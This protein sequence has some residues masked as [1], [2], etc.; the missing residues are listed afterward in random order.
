MKNEFVKNKQNQSYI[1]EQHH[2]F[3]YHDTHHDGSVS[4]KPDAPLYHNKESAGL[5][6]ALP[7]TAEADRSFAKKLP[8]SNE[9]LDSFP[10]LSKRSLTSSSTR[11][12]SRFFPP[13]PSSLNK[14][15]ATWENAAVFGSANPDF[16]VFLEGLTEFQLRPE[17]ILNLP[18]S[19]TSQSGSPA[20]ADTEVNISQQRKVSQDHVPTHTTKDARISRIH[21]FS[22]AAQVPTIAEVASPYATSS[23][24]LA[25]APYSQDEA[26]FHRL[27][28]LPDNYS[29]LRTTSPSKDSELFPADFDF[30]P[31]ENDGG[32]SKGPVASFDD[33]FVLVSASASQMTQNGLTFQRGVTKIENIEEIANL[34]DNHKSLVTTRPSLSWVANVGDWRSREAAPSSASGGIVGQRSFD[35]PSATNAVVPFSSGG[36]HGRETS[37]Q[38]SSSHTA[39]ALSRYRWRHSN[40]VCVHKPFR[41]MQNILYPRAGN[42]PLSEE[43]KSRRVQIGISPNYQGNPNNPRNRSAQIPESENCSLFV[44]NLPS[45]CTYNELL[46]AIADHRP[47]RV[48]SVYINPPREESTEMKRLIAEAATRSHHMY[49]PVPASFVNSAAKVI[50]YHPSE[51]QRLL[52]LARGRGGFLVR[53]RRA[54]VKYN[55]HRT[56]A[57]SY[58]YPTSRVISITGPATIVSEIYL[59]SLFDQYFQYHTEKIIVLGET[60]ELRCLEWRFG[61]MRAQAHSAYQLLKTHYPGVVDVVSSTCPRRETPAPIF[62]ASACRS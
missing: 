62:P 3:L 44:T 54:H 5:I 1:K 53:N 57:Q 27:K 12:V 50:F 43:Q 4:E 10:D 24:R 15:S 19:A 46:K 16:S 39:T 11:S 2:E 60:E 35:G 18:A 34:N 8:H 32:Q 28:P 40:S 26:G 25:Q 20:Q 61:S 22:R 36:F 41:P 9:V 23:Q 14:Q 58:G 55:R 30:F 31:Q 45:D 51:A 38:A 13:T 21:S 47:G 49:R 6:S 33:Q 17:A 52:A 42:E 56:G 59:T 37:S 7:P 29:T 48:W